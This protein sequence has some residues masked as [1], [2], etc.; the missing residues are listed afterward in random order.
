MNYLIVINYYER[1]EN[2]IKSLIKEVFL[3]N[4]YEVDDS[5]IV[6]VN[7]MKDITPLFYKIFEKFR[8]SRITSQTFINENLI[9]I[10]NLSRY[11]RSHGLILYRDISFDNIFKR[12]NWEAEKLYIKRL[13]YIIGSNFIPIVNILLPLYLTLKTISDL[14]NIY[15]GQ[16]IFNSTFL[17]NLRRIRNLNNRQVNKL[18]RIL[19]IKTGIKLFLKLGVRFGTKT[20]IKIG[21][22]FLDIFPIIGELINIVI[23]NLIDIPTFHIDFKEAQNEFLT[24]LKKRPNVATRRI[25]QDYNDAIN[26][27]GKRADININQNDYII[28]NVEINDNNINNLFEELD[29]L[30][31]NE[32]L[33]GDNQENNV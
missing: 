5:N 6:E 7:I 9:R 3:E 25:I 26:Y 23:G 12:K 30:D 4:E 19:A 21:M 32:L 24:E 20:S 8:N 28:P 2:S 29:N 15:L 27:F 13:V 16:P 10:S 14:H 22:S 33:I 11:S 31:I 18:L 1:I 17:N